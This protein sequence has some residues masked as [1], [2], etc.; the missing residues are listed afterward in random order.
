MWRKRN[1]C[2]E[3]KIFDYVN[4]YI[5]KHVF[6]YPVEIGAYLN[7]TI[8]LR[9]MYVIGYTI[10]YTLPSYFAIHSFFIIYVIFSSLIYLVA[11]TKSLYILDS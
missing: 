11:M 9:P 10:K 1:F 8:T 3:E 5:R 2:V 4:K 7:N 6:G